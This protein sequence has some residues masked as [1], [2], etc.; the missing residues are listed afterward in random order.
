M[1]RDMMSCTV[2]CLAVALLGSGAIG[3]MIRGDLPDF[4]WKP[5]KLVD[6]FTVFIMANRTLGS[7][8]NHPF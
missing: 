7:L 1:T 2:V 3:G 8:A 4:S 5:E 6:E